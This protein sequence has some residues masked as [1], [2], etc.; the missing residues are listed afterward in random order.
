MKFNIPEYVENILNT[1]HENGYDAYVVGGA[2]RDMIMG[3]EPSDYDVNTDALPDDIERVFKDYRTLKVGKRFGTVVVVQEEGFVEVTTFRTDGEYLDGRRPKEVFFSDELKEDLSRRDFTINAMAYN[4]KKGLVDYFG[5]VEDIKGKTIKTVGNAKDRFSED[6]LRILRAIRFATQ[7]GFSI[8]KETKKACKL[9][10]KNLLN[11][12]GERIGGELFKILLSTKPSYGIRLL[13]ELEIIYILLPEL[14]NSINFNQHNPHHDK[15]V[16][17]HSLCVLD[18]VSPVI[19]LR[20]A[21]LFHDIGKP[22]TFTRDNDGIGHFYGHHLVGAKIAWE[23]L[24]RLKTSNKIIKK[25]TILI[26]KHMTAH[27]GFGEKGLKRLLSK[28]G[29]EDIFTLLE[30][31]EADRLCTNKDA[32]ID[33]LIE[34]RNKINE[35][36]EK[37]QAYEKNQLAINGSDVIKLG[38]P[39][40]KI[41]GEILDYLFE[42]VLEDPEKNNREDLIQI[43]E[44]KYEKP[45]KKQIWE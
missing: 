10:G 29:K 27:D 44:E 36:L 20:L 19:H 39:Q 31:Q 35:I 7:L 15:D 3:K 25:T 5:G 16:F 23:I 41:I 26:E 43:I 24:L 33:D 38:Y 34:R 8:D 45:V 17:E 40:G 18:R 28:V 11:I 9:Y 42:I 37:S 32:K 4:D 22:Y 21:A 14:T 12:S 6:Y 2:V 13:N 1:L 30:L